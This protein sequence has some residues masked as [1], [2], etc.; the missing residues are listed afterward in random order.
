MHRPAPGQQD[1]RAAAAEQQQGIQVG[2][3]ATRTEVEADLPRAV[4]CLRCI[5]EGPDRLARLHRAPC[6]ERAQHRLIGGD[7]PVGMHHRDHPAVGDPA[8]EPHHT[9]LHSVHL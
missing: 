7:Q 8:A 2:L 1:A 5:L 4:R 9:R 6:R 3:P